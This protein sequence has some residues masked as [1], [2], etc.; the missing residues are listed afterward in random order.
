MRNNFHEGAP[1]AYRGLNNTQWDDTGH[2]IDFI[3]K[4]DQLNKINQL[5]N[6][7][8]KLDKIDKNL[9]KVLGLDYFGLKK[10]IYDDE[11][12]VVLLKLVPTFV[13]DDKLKYTY[14][15]GMYTAD[16]YV[17]AVVND[18]SDFDSS[19]FTYR[20]ELVNSNLCRPA[21]KGIPYFL[22]TLSNYAKGIK[23][24]ATSKENVYT[25]KIE[26]G[27]IYI[28]NK[29]L[30]LDNYNEILDNIEEA[31]EKYGDSLAGKGIG[32]PILDKDYN[33]TPYG[34]EDDKGSY[35][36]ESTNALFE[37]IFKKYN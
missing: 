19:D 10:S 9:F 25:N 14:I 27:E 26:P 20:L 13:T 15:A 21:D 7:C 6:L 17:D 33:E 28:L 2:S 11:H 37:N 34:Y 5:T 16:F 8:E 36:S 35:Y 22:S 31:I 32:M 3:L 30:N 1:Y 4:K 12:P 24:R 29:N 18:F 23:N